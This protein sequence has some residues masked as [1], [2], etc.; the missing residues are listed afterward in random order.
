MKF[1]QTE[2]HFV[3]LTVFF[4]CALIAGI[5]EDQQRLIFAGMQ[6]EHGCLLGDYAI[7]RESTLHLV[8]RLRGGGFEGEPSV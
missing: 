8:L 4:V 2:K 6:L 1:G 5:P 3:N 7:C